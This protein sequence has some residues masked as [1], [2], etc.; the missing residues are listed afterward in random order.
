MYTNL[1]QTQDRSVNQENHIVYLVST[2]DGSGVCETIEEVL[3]AIT[4]FVIEESISTGESD[5]LYEIPYFLECQGYAKGLSWEVS[6][7]PH[8]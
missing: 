5:L 3:S 8:L 1:F 6:L 2:S 4:P 7:A